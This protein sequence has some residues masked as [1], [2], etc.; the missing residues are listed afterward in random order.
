MGLRMDLIT[1][2]SAW[3]LLWQYGLVQGP[4]CEQCGLVH[5]PDSEQCG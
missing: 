1:L 2:V 4:D 5:G 3:T